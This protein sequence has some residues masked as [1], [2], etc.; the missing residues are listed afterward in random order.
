MSRS[1]LSIGAIL[2]IG[3]AALGQEPPAAKKPREALQ[4]FND[5]VGTWN[6]TATPYGTRDEQQ[7]NFWIETIAVEWQFKGGDAWIQLAFGKSKNFTTGELRY[8]PDKDHYTLALKTPDKKSLVFT[9]QL[10]DKVLTVDRDAEQETQRLV[11]TML[12]S[13]RFLYRYDVRPAGKTLFTKKYYVGATKEGESFAAGDG[14]PECV[15]S[16][17]LGTSPVTYMGKTYYVCCSGCRAE[18]QEDPAKYVKEFEEKQ[19]K[20]KK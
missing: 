20:K 9:G 13:N 8:V 17:G 1:Y 12:H 3:M 10:K 19:K 16:G 7:K 5:L 15:V 14:R 18:F 6:G 4:P 11:V 2:V